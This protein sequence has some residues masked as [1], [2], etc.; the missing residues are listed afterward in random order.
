VI[1][2]VA[3]INISGAGMVGTIGVAARVFTTLANAGV[4]IIMISQGSSQHNISFVV[5]E[6]QAK[7][8]V[9]VLHA[10]F[11]LENEKHG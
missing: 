8:A 5:K 6:A 9:Q 11:G 3:L 2:N 1:K 4:N 7:K 10:E